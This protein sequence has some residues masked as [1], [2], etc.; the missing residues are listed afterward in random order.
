MLKI[1]STIIILE[2]SCMI[3]IIPLILFIA[4]SFIIV[5]KKFGKKE[6]LMLKYLSKNLEKII[7]SI[8]LVYSFSFLGISFCTKYLLDKINLSYSLGAFYVVFIINLL[9]LVYKYLKNKD[10]V[11]NKYREKL[12]RGWFLLE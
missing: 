8:F 4:I 12:G 1:I 5:N 6:D 7:N 3:S 11:L 10:Y 2:I 9:I